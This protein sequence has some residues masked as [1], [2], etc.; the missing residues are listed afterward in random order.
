MSAADLYGE[1]AERTVPPAVQG[2]LFV[3]RNKGHV[4]HVRRSARNG[5]WYYSVDGAK[6]LRGGPLLKRYRRLGYGV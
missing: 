2:A 1:D 5:S 6:E 3:L 4:V